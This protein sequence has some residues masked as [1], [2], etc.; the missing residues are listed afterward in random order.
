MSV[1]GWRDEDHE[2][3]VNAMVADLPHD[4]YTRIDGSDPAALELWSRS[5]FQPHRREIEFLFSPDPS[6][7]RLGSASLPEGLTLL[8]ADEVDETALRE[9]DD[10]LRD[11]VPGTEGW[12]NDPAE[13]RDYTFD[14]AQ[15][16]P[17]TY[18]VAV[19]DEHRQF[20]GLVRIW[21]NDNRSR[22]GLVAVGRPYRRRGLARAMLASAL[23]PVHEGGV[24]L[25]M[26]EVDATN[27][28]SLALLSS[29]GATETG[30]SLVLQR[31][32]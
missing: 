10:R 9:L 14:E 12:I 27:A 32:F 31:R 2:P 17:A 1:D 23:R 24:H 30:Y 19:D 28:A 18:R 7:T 6:R 26:A 8:G 25:V 29:I 20:A 11:D 5:G 15:F 16:D 4:L 21:A 13:F 3:L 22:L